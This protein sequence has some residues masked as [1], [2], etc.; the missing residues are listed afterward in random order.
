[1]NF[2]LNQ[3]LTF[4]T[5]I[6]WF[7]IFLKLLLFWLWLWQLK[8]YH[9]GRFL[10]HFET[11]K[12]KKIFSSLWRLKYPK[13]T[14]KIFVIF[15]VSVIFEIILLFYLS[16]YLAIILSVIFVPAFAL[17]FQLMA[18]IWRNL[19]IAKAKKKRLEFKD[20]LVIG[21]TGSFGKTSTK[22]FLATILEDKFG[23]DKI[24]KTREHQNSE[25][26]ISKCILDELNPQHKIFIVEM[27]AYNKGGIKL[28]A[29]IVKPKIG[30]V[31]GVNEQHLSTFGSME[32]L[33]SAEGGKELVD[34][35]PQDG[36]VFFNAKNKY[37][38][39]LYNK[40]KIKK[41]IYGE[42]AK[43]FAEENLSGAIMVAKEL[44][45]TDEEI[46]EAIKK[47]ENK[48]PGIEIKKGIKGIT[49]ID[50]S[51]SANPTGV[52]AHLDYLKT[53]SG[54]KVIVMSC[55]IELGSASKE[56]HQKIGKKIAEV[57][58]LAIITTAD[59]FKEIK[60][61]AREKSLLIEKPK[62]IFEKIKSYCK[63]NDIVLLEGRVPKELITL[64]IPEHN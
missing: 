52:M 45:M 12:F 25:I 59:R 62:I 34:S 53:F 17:F 44:G 42:N 38:L 1:M 47:I 51:Y 33:L 13:F 30:V 21:I 39:D 37:C 18:V 10:A 14:L 8:E 56:I 27:A 64:L 19:V 9:F 22:E 61:E 57:C 20:L 58:D 16:L 46:S 3:I 7:F 63:E 6:I 29:D 54:K 50:A 35:L 2:T 55:L 43:N 5:Y 60:Q 48:L 41:F 40:T 4:L 26:G 23:G 31:T 24:L 36:M 28:L 11:Q 49:I 15:V 32:N